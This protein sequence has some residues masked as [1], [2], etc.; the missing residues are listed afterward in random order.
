MDW[1]MLFVAAAAIIGALEW[2]KK[3]APKWPSTVWHISLV[4]LS[5]VAAL[6]LPGGIGITVLTTGVL[7]LVTQIG[8]QLIIQGVVGL[9]KVAV[10]KAHK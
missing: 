2:L 9:I 5:I 1:G 3:L 4:P 10:A 8:Y 6:A 7:L